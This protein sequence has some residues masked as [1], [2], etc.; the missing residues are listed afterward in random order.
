MT[1][2]GKKS[3][4]D[5]FSAVFLVDIWMGHGKDNN[6]IS[7]NFY[8]HFVNTNSDKVFYVYTEGGAAN[9]DAR[10]ALVR[11]LGSQ[12]ATKVDEQPGDVGYM[13]HMRTN[14]VAVSELP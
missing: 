1:L 10:N 2:L 7:P 12:K 8:T 9:G 5:N 4:V 3:N 6:N 14:T 13:T 11:K